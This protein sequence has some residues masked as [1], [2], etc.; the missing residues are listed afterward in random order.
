MFYV[1]FS[2]IHFIY[3]IDVTITE[4]CRCHSIP[5]I[6]MSLSALALNFFGFDA[7]SFCKFCIFHLTEGYSLK[8]EYGEFSSN[9]TNPT[10]LPAVCSISGK[11]TLGNKKITIRFRTVI[12]SHNLICLPLIAQH[13]FFF[14]SDQTG[15]I[16][17]LMPEK[18]R[19]I[20]ILFIFNLS[21]FPQK[22]CI[23]IF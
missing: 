14:E 16:L 11:I 2:I 3:F 19:P 9:F 18:E 23:I 6:F 21:K 12:F 8:D 1:R 15:R 20:L 5:N 7:F 10:W 4:C 22:I 13:I 17:S